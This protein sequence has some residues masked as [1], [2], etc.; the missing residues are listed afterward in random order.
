MLP[1]FFSTIHIY[2]KKTVLV[3]CIS[4]PCTRDHSGYASAR[5]NILKKKGSIKG[6]VSPNTF[7]D[8]GAFLIELETR[9]KGPF[10][11]FLPEES[12]SAVKTA[13]Y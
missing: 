1:D 7:F 4:Y 9:L 12:K 10:H 2:V 5:F 8:I 13:K 6:T 3:P 11:L